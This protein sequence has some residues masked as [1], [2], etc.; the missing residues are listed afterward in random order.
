[1]NFPDNSMDSV[2]PLDVVQAL[3]PIIEQVQPSRAYTHH[4]G[5]L[6]VDHRVTLQPPS[7]LCPEA[8]CGN[9][10]H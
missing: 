6:N 1:M 8:V 2:T 7:A 3:E 5:D 10:D 9:S 4:H